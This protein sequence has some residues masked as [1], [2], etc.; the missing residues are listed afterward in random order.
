M[1]KNFLMPFFLFVCVCFGPIAHKKIS[2]F[3]ES[4]I[5]KEIEIVEGEVNED[6]DEAQDHYSKVSFFLHDNILFNSSIE[7]NSFYKT[8][9]FSRIYS[10]IRIPQFNKNIPNAPPVLPFLV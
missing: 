1:I 2:V 7:L 6:D 5:V 3:E 10:Y 8:Q 4:S 9:L